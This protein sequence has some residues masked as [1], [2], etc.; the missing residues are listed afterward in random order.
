MFTEKEQ[1]DHGQSRHLWDPN[2]R[3]DV[4][5]RLSDYSFWHSMLNDGTE[6]GDNW[7]FLHEYNAYKHWFDS[8]EDRALNTLK[9]AVAQLLADFDDSNNKT[10]D[11]SNMSKKGQL[12]QL[13]NTFDG[14]EE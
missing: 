14:R 9:V 7:P 1:V 6:V 3:E 10:F 12:E 11:G 13:L 4:F 2:R 5:I 8:V